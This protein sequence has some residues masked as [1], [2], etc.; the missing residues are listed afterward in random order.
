MIKE[1]FLNTLKIFWLFLPAMFA[2]RGA[3]MSKKLLPGFNF[4][5]DFNKTFRGKRVLGSHKTWRGLIVGVLFSTLVFIVQKYILKLIPSFQ[6]FGLI[7]YGSTSFVFGGLLGF[8][9]LFGDSVK[10]FFKRQRNT[11]PGEAWL[12]FDQIDW[13]L[14][15]V[16]FALP[17]LVIDLKL[18]LSMLLFTILYSVFTFYF[19]PR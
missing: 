7:D 18:I 4:P 9:S 3:L 14:G 8:G 12:P 11:K 5:I 10:S 2:N 17:F 15:T 1:I 6:D 16:L 19:Y 13:I